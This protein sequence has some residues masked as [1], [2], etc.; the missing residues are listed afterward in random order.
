[1]SQHKVQLPI[2]YGVPKNLAMSEAT[3]WESSKITYWYISTTTARISPP[4]MA[5]CFGKT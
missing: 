1:M 3:L 5:T 4:R 2:S